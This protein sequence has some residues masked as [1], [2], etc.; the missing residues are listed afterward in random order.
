MK[1]QLKASESRYLLLG[2][3]ILSIGYFNFL[4]FSSET[5]TQTRCREAKNETRSTRQQITVLLQRNLRLLFIISPNG[6]VA[7]VLWSGYSDLS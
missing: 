4:L 2:F 1:V 6:G 7:V 5:Q 3:H